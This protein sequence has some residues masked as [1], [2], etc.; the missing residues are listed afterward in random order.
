MTEG[1][2]GLGPAVALAQPAEPRIMPTEPSS[3][4]KLRVNLDG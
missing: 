4:D 1:R 3:F 2:H